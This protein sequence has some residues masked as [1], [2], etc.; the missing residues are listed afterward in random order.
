MEALTCMSPSPTGP[1]CAQIAPMISDGANHA[2]FRITAMILTRGDSL[3]F[4]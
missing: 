2:I 1:V 4:R 3:G